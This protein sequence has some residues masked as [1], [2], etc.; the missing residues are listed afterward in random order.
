M[1]T[2]PV[3]WAQFKDLANN[4]VWNLVGSG[5]PTNGTSGTGAGFAGPLSTY[6]DITNTIWY[7]NTGTK[8]S[9]SWQKDGLAGVSGDITISAAGVATIANNA[10]TGAKMANNT[11]TSTQLATDIIQKATAVILTSAQVKAVRATPITIIAAPGAGKIIEILSGSAQT[12]YAGNN[13]FTGAQN[14]ALKPKDGTTNG[15]ATLTGAGWVDQTASEQQEFAFPSGIINSK[16]NTDNQPIVLHNTGAA[17]ITGNAAGD[18]TVRVD[19]IYRIL[20]PGW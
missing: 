1:I 20:T 9:P 11:V 7:T 16:A 2:Q 19:V 10:V 13:A 12:I 4:D 14:L 3:L 18:N 6:N 8:A 5:A 17:E 15:I